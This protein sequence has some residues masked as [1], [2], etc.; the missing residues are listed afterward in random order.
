M[1][2][3]LAVEMMQS[4]ILRGVNEANMS[5]PALELTPVQGPSW[6]NPRGYG[7]GENREQ[8]GLVDFQR[9]PALSSRII[10]PRKSSKGSRST[11]WINK[12]CLI[13]QTVVLTFTVSLT[14]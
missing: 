1:G 9:S 14:G 3:V 12:E 7:P 10:H 13:D 5:V 8:G 2:A 6:K 4:S 11:A